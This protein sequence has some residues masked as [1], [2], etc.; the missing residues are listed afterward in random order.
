MTVMEIELAERAAEEWRTTAG[1]ANPAGPLYTSGVFA[2]PDIVEAE[3]R[4]SHAGCSLCT[5]SHGIA[6][7]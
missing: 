5:A 6:C 3:A 2:E 4:Y 1:P 7:C